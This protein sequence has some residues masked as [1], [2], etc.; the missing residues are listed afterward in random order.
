MIPPLGDRPR[1]EAVEWRDGEG[2]G[3][4]H[5][6]REGTAGHDFLLEIHKVGRA[7][8]LPTADHNRCERG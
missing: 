1:D 4:G 2:K 5:D 8:I 6:A 3:E 7:S